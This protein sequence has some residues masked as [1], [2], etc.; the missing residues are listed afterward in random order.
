[1]SPRGK[2]KRTKNKQYGR[3]KGEDIKKKCQRKGCKKTIT[4]PSRFASVADKRKYCGTKCAGLANRS[5]L[6]DAERFKAKLSKNKNGCLLW[7]GGT[8]AATP[9][10]GLLRRQG[11]K[12]LP[13]HRYAYELT[14]GEIK[15]GQIVTQTCGNSLCC[16]VTHLKLVSRSEIL[17]GAMPRG[18]THW[19]SKLTEKKVKAIRKASA[20]GTSHKA[21]AKKY[22]IS[23]AQV[24]LIVSGKSW[25]W[26]K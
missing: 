21:L 1:M 19:K 20:A 23:E 2:Y 4:I 15:K 13:V 6:T 17:T 11:K 24:S 7:M 10:V 3:K 14:K 12:T 16:K 18:K 25:A 26:V 5:T 9:P 8:N 22:K